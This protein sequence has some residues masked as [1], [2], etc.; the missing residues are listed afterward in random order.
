M[1]AYRVQ[2]ARA[3]IHIEQ[4][5]QRCFKI[6]IISW[7]RKE[8]EV[9]YKN[10]HTQ[11]QKN[12]ITGM[13]LI[14]SSITADDQSTGRRYQCKQS[15]LDSFPSQPRAP[16]AS[17]EEG[18]SFL[19]L[20]DKEGPVGMVGVPI[21]ALMCPTLGHICACKPRAGVSA[22]LPVRPHPQ[23]SLLQTAN[24]ARSPQNSQPAII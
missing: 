15:P 19:S 13:S 21:P 18:E 23:P 6:M 8:L 22:G 9:I 17:V 10:K 16:K 5:L 7:K 12:Q 14:N 4:K 2:Y 1:K 3:K 20:S 11:I 24:R